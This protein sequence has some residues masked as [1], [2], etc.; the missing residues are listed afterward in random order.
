MKKYSEKGVSVNDLPSTRREQFFFILKHNFSMILVV[1]LMFLI[2]FVPFVVCFFLKDI[3]MAQ[4]ANNLSANGATYS[5]L[6]LNELLVNSI[7]VLSSF[8][9]FVFPALAFSITYRIYRNLAFDEGVLFKDDSSEGI[10]LNFK[11]TYKVFCFISFSLLALFAIK[12][13]CSYYLSGTVSSLTY[14]IFVGL[15]DLTIIV[16]LTVLAL[17]TLYNIK[18]LS[19]IKSSIVFMSK[20]ILIS[21][22]IFIILISLNVAFYFASF[23][24]DIVI[25]AV[26]L[27]LILPLVVLAHYLFSL[28]LFDENINHKYPEI[29]Y[30][31]LFK[32]KE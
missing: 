24:I 32:E 30:K 6:L 19:S 16:C 7:F 2:S 17:N 21:L 8:I 23:L 10:K 26:F 4:V 5:Q 18:V 3:I 31:G 9:T 11:N 14:N 27:L 1:G 15:F 25:I 13:L 29:K 12:F 28:Y 20:G 22:A